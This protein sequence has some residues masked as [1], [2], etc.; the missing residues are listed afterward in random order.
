MRLGLG[1][2][3]RKNYFYKPQL[4]AM[5]I[6]QSVKISNYKCFGEQKQGFNHIAPINIIIGKNN[7][8]KSSLLETIKHLI[9]PIENLLERNDN[10]A[11]PVIRVS[12]TINRDIYDSL[13][14]SRLNLGLESYELDDIKRILG[15]T[16][17]FSISLQKDKF[18]KSD[19]TFEKSQL[20]DNL[21]D[22]TINLILQRL[23]TPLQNKHLRIIDAERDM[24]RETKENVFNVSSNGQFATNLITQIITTAKYNQHIATKHLLQHLNEIVN[25]D[26]TFKQIFA[27]VH[28]TD[29]KWEIFFED[30]YGNIIPLSK[31]G[32]GLKTIL[33]VLINTIVIP[34]FENRT[35]SDYVF[36]FEELENNLHPSLLRKLFNYISQYSKQYGCY[37]FITT[38]SSIVIDMF[39]NNPNAQILHTQKVGAETIVKT[40]SSA[41]DN[42]E[43]LKDIDVRASDLL[44]SNGI[45]WVEGPSDRVFINKWLQLLAPELKEGLHYSIMFYGGRLLSNLAFDHDALEKELIPLLKINHNAHVVIDKDAK[46][47]S[48]ELN[49]TKK[50]IEEEIGNDNCWITEG[51]EI[52]N[53]LSKT[54]IEAWL[55]E[56]QS[57][58][59]SIKDS[60]YSKIQDILTKAKADVKYDKDKK[61]YSLEIVNYITKDDLEN[62]DLKSQLFKLIANIKKWNSLA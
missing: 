14:H 1:I 27:K 36:I 40:V 50:R 33:L 58:T 46:S 13:Y 18:S 30:E 60:K 9:K 24:N 16:C 19:T 37:F 6:E 51:R 43:I 56:K 3:F 35:E 23:K 44:L 42:L 39:S 32:S 2:V 22:S 5:T 53:Y 61:G 10:A 59:A 29:H 52:E 31:M 47:I 4:I 45:I 55:K 26:I 15:S 62:Y 28:D 21:Q 7:S 25:P 20:V 11:S 57:I 48:S 8:G 12:A 41:T 49:Q 38:H 54:T 17:E 34:K